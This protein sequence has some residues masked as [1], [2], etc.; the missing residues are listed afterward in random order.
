MQAQLQAIQSGEAR[1]IVGTQM[2]AKGHHF[3]LLSMVG[4]VD[5]DASLFSSD[6]RS[7]ERMAQL[8]VQVAGR[9]GRE[10]DQGE[11][12]VQTH[13]VDHPLL[14]Q[15]LKEG[16]TALANSLLTERRDAELPP[17]HYLVQFRSES[18]TLKQAMDTL[19]Q[20]ATQLKS[21]AP[22]LSVLG[23][24][25]ALMSKK[26]GRY[27]AELMLK[28]SDRTLLHRALHHWIQ[29][30]APTLDKKSKYTIDVDPYDVL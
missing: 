29:H 13:Q 23:P 30:G 16:Y 26:A 19:R 14:N 15:L 20:I 2:L 6:F 17:F 27:R 28:A 10:G 25:P 3:P 8:I 22:H 1:L 4:I 18:R 24:I 9:A 12:F 5:M 21:I 7:V 11:V